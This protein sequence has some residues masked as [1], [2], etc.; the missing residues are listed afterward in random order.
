MLLWR[1]H[2]IHLVLAD[3]DTDYLC[4][5]V[6]ALFMNVTNL[7]PNILFGQWPRGILDNILEALSTC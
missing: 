4:T 5:Y 3:A 2:T 6:F 7:E 1:S